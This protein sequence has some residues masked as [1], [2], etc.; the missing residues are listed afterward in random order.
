[1]DAT[2]ANLLPGFEGMVKQ[3]AKEGGELSIAA[4]GAGDGVDGCLKVRVACC[5]QTNLRKS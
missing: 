5:L 4:T 3:G 2:Y 1:M